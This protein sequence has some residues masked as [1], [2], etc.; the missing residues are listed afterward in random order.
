MLDVNGAV[1]MGE[2]EGENLH[3]LTESVQKR[4][5]NTSEER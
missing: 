2:D 1:A 4:G 5:L 3:W